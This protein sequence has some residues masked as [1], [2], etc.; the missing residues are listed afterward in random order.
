MDIKRIIE[1]VKAN[2]GVVFETPYFIN[3]FAIR[4]KGNVDKFNDRLVVYWFDESG[5][6]HTYSP[7]KG[8]TTDPGLK[9]LRTP[10]NRAGCAVLKEGWYRRM[11]SK[12]LHNGKYSALVQVNPCTVYRDNDRD[13]EIDT[14][15]KTDTGLFGI[16]MHRANQ[17]SVSTTV[18]PYSAGCQVWASPGEFSYFMQLINKANQAGQKY[19]S[20]FLTNNRLFPDEKT[21]IIG[22][23]V[24]KPLKMTVNKEGLK[25]I[26]SFE[27]CRLAAYKCPAGVW[28]IGYGNTFYEDGTKVKEG[29]KISQERADELF[30]NILEKKFAEPVRKLLT[31]TL[32][33]NQFSAIVSFAYNLGTGNL[34]SSTLL[35]KVNANPADASIRT[36]FGKWVK[37]G[38][39]V[40]QGLVRRRAA[41]ADLYFKK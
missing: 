28:T 35:K 12:G 18:G 34:K 39:K 22:T 16:N 32:N 24:T 7:E 29:D 4:D 41:E 37:A 2:G 26:K 33:N 19:F 21:N 11:W 30:A 20:Y 15:V 10:I 8:F 17:N 23:V 27:G 31:K 38:G 1:H 36:E 40:L 6:V 13:A 25:L 5:A 14:D 3:L 9:Y